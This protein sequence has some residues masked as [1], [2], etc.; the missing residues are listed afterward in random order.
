MRAGLWIF[1]LFLLSSCVLPPISKKISRHGVVLRQIYDGKEAK[2]LDDGMIK[3]IDE[4]LD[5]L[6]PEMIASIECI[7]FNDD[8]K[9][10]SGSEWAHCHNYTGIICLKTAPLCK[11]TIW[12]EA[13]HAYTFHLIHLGGDFYKDWLEVSKTVSRKESLIER[14]VISIY[15][16]THK[17]E[18]IATWVAA[19]YSSLDPNSW[20]DFDDLLRSSGMKF[21]DLGEVFSKKLELLRKYKFISQKDYEKFLEIHN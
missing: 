13:A 5:W 7:A 11:K 18:D 19:I 17:L 4:A 14:G 8:G 9:H 21:R 20:S 12:H 15:G 1:S 6:T 10:I 3:L 2:E 16:G